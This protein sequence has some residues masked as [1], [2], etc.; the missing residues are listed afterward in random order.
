VFDA[1]V[2]V[3][4]GHS[5]HLLGLGLQQKVSRGQAGVWQNGSPLAAQLERGTASR[6]AGAQH[7]HY[8]AVHPPALPCPPAPLRIDPG[9]RQCRGG[10][11]R[12]PPPTCAASRCC[13]RCCGR[14][15]WGWRP[16]AG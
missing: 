11:A 4:D 1:L 13:P 16:G 3:V 2:V 6:R 14:H 12:G 9:A 8:T 15:S 10:R 7:W 5:Q